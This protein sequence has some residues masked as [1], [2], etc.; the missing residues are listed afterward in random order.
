MPPISWPW[1][2]WERAERFP[3]EHR[4][5]DLGEDFYRDMAR[6]ASQGRGE[7][8]LVIRRPDGR[9]LLHTKPFYPPHTWRLPSGGIRP[10]ESP[11]E[12]A[13]REV[14]EETGLPARLERLLGV[15]TY[16]LRSQAG[17]VP[18]A[19]ALFLFRTEAARPAARDADEPISGYRWV[20]PASLRRLAAH[21][22]RLPPPW[23]DWGRFRALAHDLAAAA[24]EKGL[25]AT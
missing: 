5:M 9:L 23:H 10:G 8:V 16:T 20:R 24:L 1:P 3:L 15:I 12:A 18:F 22:R 21:L 11:E 14:Q 13:C 6:K 19:S 4:E 17:E 2:D 7:V 25:P